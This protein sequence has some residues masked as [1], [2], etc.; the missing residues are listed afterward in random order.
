[1]ISFMPF[2]TLFPPNLLP[3]LF[4]LTKP[5]WPFWFL[6]NGFLPSLLNCDFS[7][8]LYWGFAFGLS[9]E[10][11]ATCSTGLTGF[12]TSGVATTS[13]GFGFTIPLN[14]SLETG[15]GFGFLFVAI[16]A[17]RLASVLYLLKYQFFFEQ[18]LNHL[19]LNLS[20]V[21]LVQ[22]S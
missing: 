2:S 11:W 21:F 12:L 5:P 13:S 19:Y 14:S 10:F 20:S 3:G 9:P 4:P 16:G 15:L 8:L 22:K 18:R 1:M 6:L 7:S 17:G